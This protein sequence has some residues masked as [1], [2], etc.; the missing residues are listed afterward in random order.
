M[1]DQKTEEHK[2]SNEGQGKNLTKQGEEV[3][4]QFNYSE[5]QIDGKG[6]YMQ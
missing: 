6:G 5:S 3:N 1:Q 2:M 4:E